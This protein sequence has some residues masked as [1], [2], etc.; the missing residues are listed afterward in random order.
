MNVSELISILQRKDPLSVVVLHDQVS[1][2]G[3]IE[4]RDIDS[5]TLRAYSRKGA[6]FLGL[7]DDERPPQEKTDVGT[8]TVL[9]VLIE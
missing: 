4:A 2:T 9:G 3:F 1:D 7:W 5:L 8:H 6:C